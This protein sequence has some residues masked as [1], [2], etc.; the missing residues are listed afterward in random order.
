V[1]K[2]FA[3]SSAEAEYNALC[4]VAKDVK[5][6]YMVLKSIGIEV[7]LPIII[8]SDNVG[9]IFMLENASA[10]A[11]TKHVDARN[12]YVREFVVEGFIRIVFVR[13]EENKSDMFTK[14]VSSELYNRHK[15]SYLIRR[16]ELLTKNECRRKGVRG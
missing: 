7:E 1:Q 8:Y 10:T 3:L 2:P 9:A 6:I 13:S 15:G 16:G 11:T 5:Y 4:E 14:N 12:H